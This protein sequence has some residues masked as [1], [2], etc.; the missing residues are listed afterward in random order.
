MG[1]ETVSAAPGNGWAPRT[2]IAL[3]LA[4]AALLASWWIEP[5]RALLWQPMDDALFRLLNGSL[6]GMPEWWS[7]FW[8]F[9]NTR[10]FDALSAVLM[11]GLYTLYILGDRRA[12]MAKRMAELLFMLLA[13]TG[14]MALAEETLMNVD[15]DSPTL[16]LG[17]E[18]RLSWMYPEFHKL[19]DASGSSFPSNHGVVL[20]TWT[21]YLWI[22]A[23]RRFGLAATALSC[24]F[25][26]PRMIGGGHWLTD[27]L[28]GGT[29][30]TLITLA[31]LFAT[32]LQ[33]WGVR[34]LTPAMR[35]IAWAAER[36]L[37]LFWKIER[38]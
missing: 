20:L 19:K 17:T 22:T 31:W 32:P 37:N 25:L 30:V 5:T 29:F 34:L 14:A 23:G 7:H 27:T 24:L 11:L 10:P 13:V 21:A 2:L 36:V 8:A 3:H 4:A 9:A 33:G 35:P 12:E 18:Y 38:P 15:R 26:L 6:G 16:V 28:V 1:G